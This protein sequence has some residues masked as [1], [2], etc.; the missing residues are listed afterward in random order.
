MQL[1]AVV[2]LGAFARG[3]YLI[4]PH[5]G[6]GGG[7]VLGVL[8]GIAL[9]WWFGFYRTLV[10]PPSAAAA[11]VTLGEQGALLGNTALT[12]SSATPATT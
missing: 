5:P 11:L 4:E 1:F 7:Y 8:F 6:G 9:G 2:H 12:T 3:H 10:V